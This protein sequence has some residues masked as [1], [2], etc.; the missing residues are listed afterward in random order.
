[1]LLALGAARA[2]AGTVAHDG[3]LG[4]ARNLSG[5]NFIISPTDGRQIGGN[6]FHSFSKLNLSAGETAN[7]TGPTSVRNVLARVTDGMPSEIDGTIRCAIPGANVFFMNP[8]GVV[9]GPNAALDIDGAFVVTTADVIKLADDGK[10]AGDAIANNS[11]LTSAEP[12]AFGFLKP[13]ASPVVI[14]GDL[15]NTTR[16][17]LVT[18]PQR[19]LSIVAGQIDVALA[20][21]DSPS[22]RV[23]LVRVDLPG[24]VIGDLASVDAPPPSLDSFQR[25]GAISL[26]ND[27]LILGTGDSSG[28]VAI[29]GG[30]LRMDRSSVFVANSALSDAPGPAI[31]AVLRDRIDMENGSSLQ[32]T[33]SVGT[34]GDVRIF[35]R[36]ANLSNSS[37]AATTTNLDFALGQGRG[38][39]VELHVRRLNVRGGESILFTESSGAG[40]G[41]DLTLHTSRITVDGAAKISSRAFGTKRCG[42][43]TVHAE[44]IDIINGGQI[45]CEAP[46]SGSTGA[47][48]LNVNDTLTLRGFESQVS[49]VGSID[50]TDPA[51]LKINARHVIVEDQAQIITIS[52][53]GTSAATIRINA[54]EL[55]MPRFGDIRNTTIGEA[56]GGVID[57]HARRI[58]LRESRIFTSIDGPGR[59]GPITID[60]DAV[61]L[62]TNSSI[63]SSPD[64]PDDPEDRGGRGGDVSIRTRTLEVLG[65]AITSATFGPGDAGTVDV[66]ATESIRFS[67]GGGIISPS[68]PFQGGPIG[69]GKAGS[70][71]LVTKLL[72]IEDGAGI[73]AEATRIGDA[74]EISVSAEQITLSGMN[75]DGLPSGILSTSHGAEA[76]AGRGGTINL[77]AKRIQIRDGAVVT[78][79]SFGPGNSGSV[80][81]RADDLSLETGGQIAASADLANG[82]E[83]II[84]AARDV[85]LAG[86]ARITAAAAGTGGNIVI[87]AGRSVQLRDSTITAAA[88]N[89]GNISI[90]APDSVIVINSTITAQAQGTGGAI[91][92]DPRFVVLNKS[93]INGLAGGQDVLMT[94]DAGNLLVSNDSQI[95]TDRGVFTVDTDLAQSLVGFDLGVRGAGA[96]LQQACEVRAAGD[97]SSFTLNGAGGISP[98]PT[99]PAPAPAPARE[100]ER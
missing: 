27:S 25:L 93:T 74:G 43:L 30:T 20:D 80:N 59:G 3:S 38:G 76:G 56:D 79:S 1:M 2:V 55:T 64:L 46:I 69:G 42:D 53:S 19:T 65:S 83:M 11:V 86:G 60:A 91:R 49:V 7:F 26:A 61:R 99:A 62:D 16:V 34:G 50:S 36:V 24:D 31:D 41:G 58:D 35:A 45:S 14:A 21:L 95:L 12:S 5:P 92:I 17:Q 8:A 63:E 6:L 75:R 10:F 100:D 40:R 33:T 87:N 81:I 54:D 98:D 67:A 78:S 23:N 13:N 51:A 37:V 15:D 44:S 47:L 39:N 85:T 82:G 66:L 89:Q 52:G 70:I 88:G 96:K 94:I 28:R 72:T 77:N 4:P 29:R 18:K 68:A 71:K 48:T 22:G 73:R 57:I 9:F 32:S 84:T 90:N 97:V